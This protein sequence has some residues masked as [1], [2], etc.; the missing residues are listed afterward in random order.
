MS[1][2]AAF[3]HASAEMVAAVD[4]VV[5]RPVDALGFIRAAARGDRRAARVMTAVDDALHQLDAAPPR[6]PLLCAACPQPLRPG[7]AYSFVVHLPVDERTPYGFALG[8]CRRCATSR[9]EVRRK[10]VAALRVEMPGLRVVE[11]THASGGRA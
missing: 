9:A 7:T 11:A 5:C 1:T 4:L 10:A 8:I 3:L 6:S 2:R